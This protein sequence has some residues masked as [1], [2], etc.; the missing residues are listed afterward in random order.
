[1]WRRDRWCRKRLTWPQWLLCYRRCACPA[2]ICL[3]QGPPL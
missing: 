2:M 3:P 1:M